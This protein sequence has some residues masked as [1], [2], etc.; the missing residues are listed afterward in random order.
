MLEKLVWY[1]PSSRL[2]IDYN[3][4]LMTSR[5]LLVTRTLLRE[6]VLFSILLCSPKVFFAILQ[7]EVRDL[8]N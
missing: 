5:E 4:F 2:I 8:S 7:I 6:R 3:D 1:F